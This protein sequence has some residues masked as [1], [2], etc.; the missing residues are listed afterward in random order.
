M[1]V[2]IY[3]TVHHWLVLMGAK[4]MFSMQPLLP[5]TNECQAA[6]MKEVLW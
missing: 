2:M 4:K 6:S 3:F 1:Q 5:S